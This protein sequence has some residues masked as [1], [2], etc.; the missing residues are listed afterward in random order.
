MNHPLPNFND[1]KLS[2]IIPSYN[3]A[4]FL[5]EAI[6]SLLSQT[7][8]VFEIIVVDDGST[9][10]TKEVCDRY[11]TVKYIYQNN[12]GAAIARNT[13]IRV[14]KGEY[15]L[16]LDSDDCLLPK[17]VEIGVNC[18]NAHPEVG[19]VFGSYIFQS[20]NPD[21]SYSTEEIYDNQ[22][23][24]ASYETLLAAKHKIQ[25]ACIVFRRVAIESVGGFNQNLAPMEDINFFLRIAREFPIYFHG[26]IVSEY[27]YN[28]NNLSSQAAKMLIIARYSHSLQWS[29]VQQ[30]GN[31]EYA[32]AYECGKQ[33]WTKLF[34]ERLPYEIMRYVQAGQWVSALGALRLILNY[35]PKLKCIDREVYEVSYKALLSRLRELPIQSSLAYWKQQLAGAPPLLSLPTDRPRPAEQTGRGSSQSFS[36][37][38]EL[39]EALSLL[40]RQEQVTVFMTLLAAF[41]TLLYRYTG[42]EDIVVGSPFANCDRTDIKEAIFVNALPIRTDISGNPKFLELLERVRKVALLAQS[43]QDVPFEILVEELQPQRDLSYSPFFQVMFVMEG[44]IS[45]QKLNVSNLTASP[46]LVEDNTAKFDLTLFLEPTNNGLEGKWI[47]NAD[48]FDADTIERMNGHFQTLLEGI[49]ANPTQPIAELPLLRAKEKQQLLVE[50][51]HTQI[52][53]PEDKCIHQ[54]FEEQ[55]KSTPDAIAVVFEQQQLTYQELNSRANQLAHY[56]KTLGVGSDVPIGICV[57]RS[58]EMVV[59]LLGILKA[60][61]AYVPLD[62][63]YP[64]ERLAYMLSDSQMPVLLTQ[65]NLVSVLPEHQAKVVYLD[66]DWKNISQG[67]DENPLSSVTVENLAYIIYTSGSTGKPKGVQIIHEAVTNFLNSM[68]LK[69]GLTDKDILLAITTISFDIAVLE[70]YL[71][72]MLGAKVILVSRE[73][74]VDGIRLLKLLNESKATVMQATP[75]TW[76]LLLAAG[77]NGQSQLKILCGGEALSQ[78]LASQLLARVSSVWNMYGPTEATVWATTYE[79]GIQQSLV[80]TQKPAIYIGK[81]IGN[82]QTY[83]LDQY[84]QPVPI[85]I[86]G[87]LYI[88]GVCLARGYL[89]RPDLT[90]EK[91]IA[92]PF[93]NE[94]NSRLYKTGDLARYLPNGEIEYISRIDNQVKIRGFRIELGEIE[95]LLAKHPEIREIAVIVREDVPGDKRLVA[96]IVSNQDQT[97]TVN[98]LRDFLSQRLPKYMIPSAFVTLDALPLTPNGKVDRRALLGYGV[99]SDFVSLGTTPLASNGKVD[100]HALPNTSRI[101]L[102]TG[103]VAPRN[104]TE[105]ILVAIWAEVLGLK[106]I[107][108]HDNF[109]ALGGH[110]LLAMRLF[111][112]IEKSLGKRLSLATLFQKQTIAELA[113]ILH[114]EE[115][116]EWESL[117]MIQQGKP[118]KPSLFCIHAI[119]GN[120]LFYRKLAQ[121]LL[122]DQPFYG[123]QA[124]GLDGKRSPLTSIPEMASN[125][126]K[127]MQRIQPQGPYFLGGFSLGG[128][129]AFEIAQQLHALG[130]EVRLLAVFD[131]GS[132]LV[133]QSNGDP[134]NTKPKTRWELSFSHLNNLL[135]L[136]PRDQINYLWERINWHLTVGKASIFYKSYLRYIKRSFLD[137]RILDVA[138]ANHQAF[139]SYVAQEIYPGTV[140]LFLSASSF[141]KLEDNPQLWDKAATGGVEIYQ[142]PGAIHTTLMEEPNVRLLAEKL[143]VCLQQVQANSS[144]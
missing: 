5:P 38:Q 31:K 40:S 82:T 110:S 50:W 54:L 65:Q 24:V 61:G 37:S 21:G 15:L 48:L 144:L 95:I 32:A 53:Y 73:V 49:I 22:P 3:S 11:P 87:E 10:E 14:S 79:V 13:G 107:G 23:E 8:P 1:C 140:T 35:D 20:M 111:T 124:Q 75:A 135:N 106:Q 133:T 105:E 16:F 83:I 128:Q 64:K 123:L 66:T 125:Y 90:T 44:D 80:G 117:V 62:P 116:Q 129:I 51:N 29:Y 57:E 94:P 113:T 70:L 102:K 132:P 137:L 59:G 47:Y 92:N 39:T 76:H 4:V 115:S 131:C 63:A 109:F 2:V 141:Q 93:S 103:F 89:N 69:P 85:G 30:T 84:L 126:I 68:Q 25:C 104:P 41:N 130:Q 99:P 98:D 45:L 74:A 96:Y 17:A 26:Q 121:Y 81:P 114:Q 60:G 118:T 42:T 143:T 112:Q 7:Y 134:T 46:W 58:L 71:P 127:E 43:H 139:R 136:K 122:P 108:I 77:W 52:D 19:F 18:I 88:G 138:S 100:S 9:D 33:A 97:P 86:S 91:F 36:L 101:N 72:L 119:W 120:V 6:E 28:G 34:V 55:V 27:R 56:L 78:Q 142:I 12:Q 67:N